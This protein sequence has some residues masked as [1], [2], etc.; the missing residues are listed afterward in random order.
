MSVK[1]YRRIYAVPDIHGRLDLL[2]LLLE[3]LDADGFD[4]SQDLIVFL[5]DF[6][7]RGPDSRGVVELVKRLVEDGEA[8]AVS[9]NHE[10]FAIDYYVKHMASAREIWEWNGGIK[11]MMSYADPEHVG[12]LTHVPRMSEEHVRFLAGLP[13][14]LEIQGFFFSHA[15]VPRQKARVGRGPKFD[16]SDNTDKREP[17]SLWE[18]TWNYFGPECEKRGAMMDVHEGPL[19]NRGEGT[20]HLTGVC[21]H[22]HRGPNVR[23]VRIFNNYRMLDCGS[24]CFETGSLAAHECISG[25]TLY[26]RPE[27]LREDMAECTCQFRPIGLQPHADTTCPEYIKA[28]AVLER[29]FSLARPNDPKRF[30]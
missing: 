27:D 7:D 3:K 25:R 29:D 28:H 1:I 14:S 16:G 6:I 30:V 5:G 2:D 24:G 20:E 23:D 19:N 10:S 8:K 13:R 26:A 22:I 15:P 18:L 9:G 17:Y 21:G 11:T 4:K 12:P